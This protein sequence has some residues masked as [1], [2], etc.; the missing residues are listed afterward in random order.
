[1]KLCVALDLAS[2]D[3]NL[4]IARAL[5]GLDIWLKVGLRSYLRDG[6]NFLNELKK[7]DDFKIFVDLKIY[8]IP[9]TMA[10]AAEVISNIGA[11]MINLHASSGLRA[12]SEV[13]NRLANLRE[14]PLVL[15]VSALTSFSDDEFYEVY[16]QNIDEAVLKMSQNAKNAGLDGMV[17]SVFESLA[18]KKECGT[19]FITLTPGIRPFKGNSD[20]QKRVANIVMA[21]QNLS[22]FIVVG[23]PIYKSF[24]PRETVEKI[25]QEIL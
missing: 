10:D 9:N 25:L 8:D 16:N 4:A 15:A 13:M 3:E 21:K 12:M 2:R 14:K 20:D 1:M 5:K 24:N 6:A 22:D 7:I 18:I 11:D 17:C 19:D 23:R